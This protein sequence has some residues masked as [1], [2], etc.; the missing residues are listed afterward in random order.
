MSQRT[1]ERASAKAGGD[2]TSIASVAVANE[3]EQQVLDKGL[4]DCDASLEELLGGW[5]LT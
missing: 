1:A 3:E 2:D 4:G 5:D